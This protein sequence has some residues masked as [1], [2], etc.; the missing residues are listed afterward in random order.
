MKRV[1]LLFRDFYLR[2]RKS[3]GS[4]L[5]PEA[6]ALLKKFISEFRPSRHMQALSYFIVM[7]VTFVVVRGCLPPAR[8][9]KVPSGNRDG[10]AATAG[11]SR[12]ISADG[13]M[14]QLD[15]Q[16]R[17]V[18]EGRVIDGKLIETRYTYN[19]EGNVE[20]VAAYQDDRP[21]GLYQ[22]F[23]I[24]GSLYTEQN[25]KN[26]RLDGLKREY[27]PE[28][29]LVVEKSYRNDQ[30][31]GLTREYVNGQLRAERSYVN[32][33]L[34]GPSREFD[35]KGNVR[36]L[37]TYRDNLLH[38]ASF[39]YDYLGDV[40]REYFYEDGDMVVDKEFYGNKMLMRETSLE[41]G[42][43]KK[44]REYYDT[45]KLMRE[46]VFEKGRLVSISEHHENGMPMS[47]RSYRDGILILE[48]HYDL[49]GNLIQSQAY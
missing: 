27:S 42:K 35:D 40:V 6:A 1:Q 23:N 20:T 12:Q 36:S 17:L 44:V 33:K 18:A 3:L 49:Q 41:Q 9:G 48:E 10:G 25:Y 46:K 47:K 32:D 16:G 22:E 24:F 7:V 11:L 13:Q 8:Q 30:L 2:M 21:H 19:Y 45:G 26:G 14:R 5:T 29:A 31:N 37:K 39:E 4:F 28:G 15:A 43:E 38:G 34:T